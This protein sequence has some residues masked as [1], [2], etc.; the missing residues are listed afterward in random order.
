MNKLNQT[1]KVFP[2]ILN[3]V[4]KNTCDYACAVERPERSSVVPYVLGVAI[5]LVG[6]ITL[7]SCVKG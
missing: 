6:V 4:F 3:Q 2:R 5:A 7:V 1:P